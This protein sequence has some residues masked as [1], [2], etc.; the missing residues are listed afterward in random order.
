M[1]A[2]AATA[3]AGLGAVHPA[4]VEALVTG[5]ARRVLDF[6]PLCIKSVVY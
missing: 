4:I 5:A 2:I 6:K 3:V 1:T